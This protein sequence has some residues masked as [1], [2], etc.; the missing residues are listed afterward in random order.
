LDKIGEK[1]VKE[2]LAKEELPD[3]LFESYSQGIVAKSEEYKKQMQGLL[4][5]FGVT[6]VEFDPYLV[7]GLDY[8]TGIIFEF[9]LKDKPE[10]GSVGGGGRYDNLIGKISGTEVPAVGGSIGLDRMFA[11]LQE[12]GLISPQ[13]AAEVIILNQDEAYTAEYLNMATNLRASCIDCE[14]FYEPTKL[15]KQFKYAE[16]KNIK[17]AVIYGAEEAKKKKV[18]IKNLVE[19]KQVTVDLED[20]V[21]EV[22][23]MLW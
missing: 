8:Y 13:T 5:N 2:G 10:F 12:L 1:K 11:A 9:V 16:K 7:R 19:K 15:D 3:D 14:V 4:A 6:E 17:L 18:N 22:K 21:S 23:S 20:L